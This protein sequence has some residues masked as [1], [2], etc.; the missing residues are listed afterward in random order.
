[1]PIIPVIAERVDVTYGSSSRF[2]ADWSNM[3]TVMD[4]TH[5]ANN[6]TFTAGQFYGTLDF[7][8]GTGVDNHTSS[9]GPG[10]YNVFV[11]KVNADGSYGYTK[12]V[13]SSTNVFGGS[14][15]VDS[16][17]SVYF[18]VQYSATT[19]LNPGSGVDS[20][21]VTPGSYDQAIIKLNADGSYNQSFVLSGS[22][23]TYGYDVDVDNSNNLYI[24][25]RFTET[26]DF[27]P[28]SG[29]DNK[30]SG[31]GQDIFLTKINADGTY[32]YTHTIGGT[33]DDIAFTLATASN[34]DYYVAGRVNAGAGTVDFNPSA[35]VDLKTISV[36]DAYYITKINANG[37]YGYTNVW[38][39]P[40]TTSIED[41]DTDNNDNLYLT[42]R[43]KDTFDFNPGAGT[44][45]KSSNGS[46]RSDAF[47]TK[48]SADGTYA[49]TKA[50]GSSS[51]SVHEYGLDVATDTSNNV[52]TLSNLGTNVD[53]DPGSGTDIRTTL[54]EDFAV[55]KFDENG[56]YLAGYMTAVGS[57]TYAYVNGSAL[58]V[59]DNYSIYITAVFGS[60]S[61][62]LNP[63]SGTDII[64]TT[65][66]D[67]FIAKINQVVYQ[68]ITGLASG[69][70]A[71]TLSDV[72]ASGNNILNGT[73]TTIRLG[74]TSSVPI[75]DVQTLFNDDLDW[76]AVTADSDTAA[77]KA[78]VH[79][80]TAAAGTSDSFT[81]YVPKLAGHNGVGICPNVSSLATTNASCSGLYYL[82]EGK[83]DAISSTVINNASYWK[84]TGLT[85]T[86]G[87]STTVPGATSSTGTLANTGNGQTA[88]YLLATLQLA[89]GVLI[90]GKALLKLSRN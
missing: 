13:S 60:G 73:T 43:F 2:N 10:V 5:D 70:T 68:Q 42:G 79:N 76:S 81:L 40:T 21:N 4:I 28:G 50:W 83:Q 15:A 37:T 39:T 77:G 1:M 17:G 90:G 67:T 16:S 85:G 56:N 58:D 19:D 44:D 49:F 14:L 27:N 78:F 8:L 36:A 74:K 46:A 71:E 38:Q 80:L 61:I 9:G 47:L 75:A 82:T 6:N 26:T 31:G 63:F 45:N 32:G 69:L 23:I 35:G 84:V 57:G 72:D 41:I 29:V 88:L 53:L 65:D 22:D 12:T 48:F 18:G 3:P 52:Y 30:V 62:D 7:N 59:A 20:K 87:F 25:G 54:S 34:S 66:E 86:G 64:S 11:T 55:S 51:A 89:F 33:G 24:A